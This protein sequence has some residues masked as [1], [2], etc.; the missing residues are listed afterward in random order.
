M[1][2]GDRYEDQK[3]LPQADL[4]IELALATEGPDAAVAVAAETLNRYDLSASTPRYLLPVLVSAAA[5]ARQT[6]GDA[7]EGLLCKL[8]TLVEKQDVLG[9]VQ[10]A[11]LLSYA[12]VDPR[13]DED[14]VG[15]RL[16]AADAA[17]AAWEAI[18]QP[19]PAALALVGAARVALSGGASGR[20]A[21]A[22]RLRR[23]APIAD[24]LGARPLADQIAALL[25][26]ATG[27]ATGGATGTELRPARPDRPRA[28]G[29]PASSR[30]ASPTARSRPRCSSRRRRPACTSPTS[31]PSSARPPAPR[32]PP[33]PTPS[34][35]STPK[36]PTAKT[37]SASVTLAAI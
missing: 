35:Y 18:G 27:S 25:L 24:R 32:P 21:G 28:R 37:R 20:E 22:A 29:A 34:T 13:P 14:T 1:L 16:A 4:D 9:P 23:A 33:A 10:H 5:A 15:A 7:A 12:A 30:P 17:A 36:R 11:W 2:A 26:R 19:Y 8:R 31:S 3:H 6:S